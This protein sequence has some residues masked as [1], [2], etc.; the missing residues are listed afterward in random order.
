MAGKWNA[1]LDSQTRLGEY[2]KTARNKKKNTKVSGANNRF[3]GDGAPTAN[4]YVASPMVY[5]ASQR[6]YPSSSTMMTDQAPA[7]QYQQMLNLYQQTYGSGTA[8]AN[9]NAA[10]LNAG[11]PN[12]PPPSGTNP[13]DQK[14]GTGGGGNN[15]NETPWNDWTG[16][17]DDYTGGIVDLVGNPEILVRDM[18]KKLG[19]DADAG[20]VD[21]LQND[22]GM[23]EMLLL[24]GATG[25]DSLGSMTD[26]DFINFTGD[27]TKKMTTPG[28][29]TPDAMALIQN[30][31][32]APDGSA[33]AESLAAGTP[34]QQ[35]AF[36]NQLV[37]VAGN[38][39]T[40]LAQRALLSSLEGRTDD[41]LSDQAKGG[42]S[43]LADWLQQ[44]GRGILG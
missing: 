44:G 8:D 41:W 31:L 27:W 25:K 28:A 21:A 5:D 7:S 35:A 18:L 2:Q 40:P 23:L 14:G 38:T 29:G 22:A 43:P 26:E 9:A 6:G 17:A 42:K 12:S 1:I 37:G 24:L 11:N 16:F 3:L 20:A 10:I 13:P 36:L 33:L 19:F 34:E 15:G 32:D 4:D 39:L 30:I